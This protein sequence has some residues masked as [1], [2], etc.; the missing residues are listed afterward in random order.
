MNEP[1]DGYFPGGEPGG[2]H[3]YCGMGASAARVAAASSSMRSAAAST[4]T[5]RPR[6]IRP[7]RGQV[8]V[9][10]MTPDTDPEGKSITLWCSD[11]RSRDVKTHRGVVLALGPPARV[12]EHPDSAEV[13]YGFG[14]GDV[15]QYHFAAVGTQASRTR[16][17]TDGEPAT[18]LCQAEIDAVWEDLSW[19]ITAEAERTM[20]PLLYVEGPPRGPEHAAAIEAI[21]AAGVVGS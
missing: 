17:W 21:I 20:K 13:P 2:L 14:V 18:W 19:H 11:P 9:R 4:H 8:V 7:M 16:A 15:V 6:R 3:D 1:T 10:E 5:G 12:T